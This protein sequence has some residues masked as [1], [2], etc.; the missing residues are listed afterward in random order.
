MFH[1][2]VLYLRIGRKELKIRNYLCRLPSAVNVMLNLYNK[3]GISPLIEINCR[4]K[5]R[6]NG[7]QIGQIR[8][9]KTT[10]DTKT[11]KAPVSETPFMG[12]QSLLKE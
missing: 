9:P 6:E 1:F 5:R 7:T 2:C 10:S 11:R 8:K 3:L 4:S 12:E